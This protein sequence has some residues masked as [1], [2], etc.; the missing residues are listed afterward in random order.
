MEK[1]SLGSVAQLITAPPLGGDTL[2]SDSH[3][4]YLGLP[5]KLQD[6]IQHLNG[7]HDYRSF[8]GKGKYGLPEEL[9][10]EI[11]ANIPFGVSHPLVRTHPE[12]GKAALY[13]HA[14][15]LRH[16]SLFDRHTGEAIG[17]E[18]SSRI[19]QKLLPRH[20]RPEYICRFQW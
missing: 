9:V 2:F 7:V 18:T 15:F 6:E 14:G 1:P 10:D 3:A 5:K 8:L 17:A 13:P 20:N 12:T 16:D 11:K 19:V 4:C